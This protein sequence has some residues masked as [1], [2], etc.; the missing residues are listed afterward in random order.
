ML[1]K[2]RK[3]SYMN[4]ECL[5]HF[6]LEIK[7]NMDNLSTNY[8]KLKTSK[9][10]KWND[11]KENF[12]KLENYINS[13][14]IN[15]LLFLPFIIS[16]YVVP[17]KSVENV[18]YLPGTTVVS[19]YMNSSIISPSSS[20]KLPQ[21]N[22]FKTTTEVFPSLSHASDFRKVLSKDNDTS[23]MNLTKWDYA[24]EKLAVT[25]ESNFNRATPISSSVS[26]PAK[27]HVRNSMRNITRIRRQPEGLL[28]SKFAVGYSEDLN[29]LSKHSSTVS[30][31]R[32]VLLRH[33]LT[34]DSALSNKLGPFI[35]ATSR[36]CSDSSK[37]CVTSMIAKMRHDEDSD[38]VRRWTDRSSQKSKARLRRAQRVLQAISSNITLNEHRKS[39]NYLARK[40]SVVTNKNEVEVFHEHRRDTS[41]LERRLQQENESHYGMEHRRSSPK[42]NLFDEK[43]KKSYSN[44]AIHTKE[45][46]QM[47]ATMGLNIVEEN[48]ALDVGKCTFSYSVFNGDDYHKYI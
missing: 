27:Y 28:A 14:R 44:S 21:A 11:R 47:T 36:S 19:D 7:R 15:I 40:N 46:H 22:F 9:V 13:A 1:R 24:H 41:E 31:R 10:G 38:L 12:S 30:E 37:T 6:F 42:L 23:Q 2:E 33:K 5:C 18:S 48:P 25:L 8:S 17:V 43:R 29:R 26:V 35:K 20:I 39:K 4:R 3:Y 32:K 34:L 16:V 45:P